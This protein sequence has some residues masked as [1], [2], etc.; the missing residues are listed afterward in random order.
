M[1]THLTQCMKCGADRG[2]WC[3][4]FC[5]NCV[6]FLGYVPTPE[7]LHSVLIALIDACGEQSESLDHLKV[8][9]SA[10][11]PWMF[12]QNPELRELLGAP[13]KRTYTGSSSGSPFTKVKEHYDLAEYVS[14]FTHLRRVGPSRQ[15]GC[16]PIHGERTASF[17][18]YEDTQTWRCFGGCAMGGDIISLTR[19]LLNKGVLTA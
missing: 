15:K 7:N 17:Y 5:D 19:E 6:Q 8:M 1:T 13:I 16:C 12:D 14:R 10:M 4:D 3:D 18:V 11:R 2:L 9:R